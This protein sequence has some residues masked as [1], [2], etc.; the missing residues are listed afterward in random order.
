MWA[1]VL[2][3]VTATSGATVYAVVEA[4]MTRVLERA[5]TYY[6]S[7]RDSETES[8]AGSGSRHLSQARR[9]KDLA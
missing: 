1:Q 3:V 5:P 7:A 2:G 9:S 8:T 4:P 6:A